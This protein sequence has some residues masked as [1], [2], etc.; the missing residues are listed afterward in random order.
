VESISGEIM[1]IDKVTPMKGM[2]YGIHLKVKAGKERVSVQLGSAWYIERLDAKL[3][4]GDAVE[5]K[6]SRITYNGNPAI[7]AAE[8]RK[9]DTA[10]KLRFLPIILANQ[11]LVTDITYISTDATEGI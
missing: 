1:A 11:V 9:A 3:A 4:K 10:L 6:G 2:D 8:V 7:V 5:V